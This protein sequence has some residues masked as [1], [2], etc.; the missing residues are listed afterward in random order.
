MPA[1]D[2]NDKVTCGSCGTLV[3]QKNLS[4]HKL[5]SSGGALFCP[6][7][8]KFSTK[9]G[10]DL[11]YHIAKKHSVPRTSITYK[12]KLCHAEFPGFYALRQ[13]KNIQYG[14]EI[15]F[16]ANNLMWGT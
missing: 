14:T 5:R 4:R 13:H 11:N 2:R 1:L 10:E 9:S 7:S 6:K 16:G 8:P 3:T 12:C 15:G